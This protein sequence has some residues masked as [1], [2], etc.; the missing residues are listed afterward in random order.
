MGGVAGVVGPTHV[1]VP[2]LNRHP[3]RLP[4]NRARDNDSATAASHMLLLLLLLLLLRR[5]RGLGMLQYTA[6]YNPI[7]QTHTHTQ[8]PGFP[9]TAPYRAPRQ[10][11]KYSS[12]VAIT[13]V[14][15]PPPPRP[16]GVALNFVGILHTGCPLC[17]ALI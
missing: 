12:Q 4:R 14:R 16:P 1:A 5:R 6:G 11:S 2:F 17:P 8:S 10:T 3:S 9:K 15:Q 13:S 7:K